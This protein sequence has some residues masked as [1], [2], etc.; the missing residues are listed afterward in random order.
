MIGMCIW[1]G[2]LEGCR[3]NG[4]N[5]SGTLL[6][7]L[8]NNGKPLYDIVDET[9]LRIVPIVSGRW[10]CLGIVF[11]F[12]WCGV[13]VA[14]G[15]PVGIGIG[16]SSL[17]FLFILFGRCFLLFL[18]AFVCLFMFEWIRIEIGVWVCDEYVN[19]IRDHEKDH[20]HT[21]RAMRRKRQEK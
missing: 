5:G 21:V 2:W 13:F 7:G 4:L 12:V 18:S 3:G 17:L 6:F 15:S 8:C 10:R 1:L 14:S 19:A 9:L 11:G 16:G 20:T